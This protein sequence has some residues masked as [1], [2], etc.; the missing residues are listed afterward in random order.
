MKNLKTDFD[1]ESLYQGIN[2]F[3]TGTDLVISIEEAVKI[4]NEFN[5]KRNEEMRKNLEE[6]SKRNLI[7]SMKFLRDN[8]KE[9]GVIETE[10]GLQYLVLK[11]GNGPRPNLSDNVQLHYIGTLL[12]GTEFDNSKARGKPLLFPM[13]GRKN[14]IEGWTEGVQKMRVGSKYKFFIPPSLA[15]GGRQAGPIITPNSLLIFEVEMLAIE[16]K[17]RKKEVLTH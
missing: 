1:L 4:R 17:K 15:Y 9:K 16:E 12:N 11:K 14:I 6:L 2:D 13:K 3:Y 5:R 7:E 10:T 8:K